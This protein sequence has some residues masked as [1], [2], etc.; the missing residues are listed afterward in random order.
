MLGELDIQKRVD[1]GRSRKD[2]VRSATSWKPLVKKMEGPSTKLGLHKAD[3][4]P[5]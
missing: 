3:L 2:C 5:E 1:W 4:E